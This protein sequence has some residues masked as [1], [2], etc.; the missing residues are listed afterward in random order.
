MEHFASGDQPSVHLFRLQVAVCP[1]HK[2]E[3]ALA[4]VGHG[5][6]SH[7]G[8]SVVGPQAG[9]VYLVLSQHPGQVGAESVLAHLSDKRGIGPQ[10][11]GSHCYVGRGAAGIGGKQRYL[12]FI[13]PGLGQVNQY[14][15]NGGNIH[16][17]QSFPFSLK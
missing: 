1:P 10:P 8:G 13:D 7:G 11:G 3:G 16:H 14:F 12:L 17:G 2:A 6:H 5:H 9:H 4:G 15:S